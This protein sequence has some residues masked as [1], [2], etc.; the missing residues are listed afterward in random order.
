MR[1]DECIL[2]VKSYVEPQVLQLLQP[3]LLCVGTSFSTSNAQLTLQEQ[4][5]QGNKYYPQLRPAIAPKAKSEQTHRVWKSFKQWQRETHIGSQSPA[6]LGLGQ[7]QAQPTADAARP[8]CW[9]LHEPFLGSSLSCPQEHCTAS[10][11][12]AWDE[13]QYPNKNPLLSEP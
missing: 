2:W 3:K 6:E 11:L 7:W 8:W 4:S 9:V 10:L 12:T 1:W 5:P 13:L